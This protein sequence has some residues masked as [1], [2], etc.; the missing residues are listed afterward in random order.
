MGGECAP[1]KAGS[2]GKRL[3]AN[4]LSEMEFLKSALPGQV[5]RGKLQA[6]SLEEQSLMSDKSERQRAE[7][8][9][10]FWSKVSEEDD[11]EEPLRGGGGS[12]RVLDV[13][14]CR[15]ECGLSS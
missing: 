7:D 5:W 11:T 2:H 1:G 13:R 9:S 10:K 3:G 6:E 4:D 12:S 15:E 14:A 8:R